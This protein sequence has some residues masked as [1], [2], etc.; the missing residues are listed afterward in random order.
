M[1]ST[2]QGPLVTA[3]NVDLSNCDREQIQYVGAVQPHGAMLVLQEPELRIL[4]ASSNTDVCFG[5]PTHS[6]L[7]Q[8]LTMLMGEEQTAT[9]AKRVVKDKLDSVPVHV[10]QAWL[11]NNTTPF[12]VFAHRRDGVLV[13]EL[14]KADDTAIQIPVTELYSELRATISRLQATDSLQHFFDLT[15]EQIRYFTGFERVLSYQFLEDGAGKVNAESIAEGQGSYLGHHYPASDIPAPARR[16]FSMS[17]LR[18]L[19]DVDYQP[20]SLQPE[21]NPLN[22]QPLDLS[23]SL[24]RSVSVMYSGYLKN[25]GVKSTMVMPLLKNGQLWG[26]ISCMHHSAPRHVP[27]EVRMACEFL[28]HMVSLLLGAKIDIASYAYRL[29]LGT[30]LEQIVYRMASATDFARELTQPDLNVLSNLDVQ[31]AAVVID[32]QMKTLGMTPAGAELKALVDWLATQDQEIVVSTHLSS[33]YP[34]AESVKGTASG[35]MAVRLSR[36]RPDFILW[37]R[38]EVIQEVHWAGDP[39]KPV[40]VWE[41]GGEERLMPRT[42]FALWKETVYGKSRP[43]QDCEIEY[44]RDLR[45]AIMEI[46]VERAEALAHANRELERSNIELDSFAYVASHDLKEPLRGIHNFASM[47]LQEQRSQ[48]EPEGVRRL[49]A[50]ARLTKRMEDLIESLLHYSRVGRSEFTYQD[51]DLNKIVKQ[52]L[53]FL[54]GRLRETGTE[55]RIPAP[56]PILQGDP[57]QISEIY[58]NLI[59]NAIKYN[60]KPKRWVEIGFQGDIQNPV[61]YVR[62][63]G[64][65]I[66]EKHHDTVFQIFKRLHGREQYGGGTGAGLTIVKKIIERHGGYIR[67]ESTPGVGTSFYFTLATS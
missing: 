23:Y 21:L 63:N 1:T 7:Q 12:N 5:T 41:E 37:F 30:A 55:V 62:D 14:E 6:L 46:I 28:A 65:G 42:S 39:H 2:Q 58:S 15:V 29:K 57:M 34:P 18:Y 45:R 9:I 50:M 52:V 10:L 64:I 24:L 31:G 66:P 8:S 13:L 22:E 38:P 51:V 32:G 4:Q 36:K 3:K 35:L 48:L 11:P 67:L 43:W 49:E 54:G 19:P 16:L 59:T 47:L 56:L 60:D 40:E 25:M 33:L 61:L 20:V 26:L 27:Y 53:E 17:W 44:A